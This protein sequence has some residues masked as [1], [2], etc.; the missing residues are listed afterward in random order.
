VGLIILALLLALF[1]VPPLRA[2]VLE[3]L[4]LGAVRIFLS[5]P[6]PTVSSPATTTPLSARTPVT[7][8]PSPP[9]TPSADLLNL[10]GETTLAEA[11]AQVDFPIRLP[12]EPLDLGS[13]DKVYLQD[14]NGPV[15]ILVWLDPDQPERVRLSLH[16]FGPNTLAGK[17]APQTLQETTVHDH[18]ALWVSG[19]HL[20]Q[21]RG[22][23]YDLIRLVEGKVLIWVE[24]DLTYRLETEGSLEEAVRMAESLR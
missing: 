4:Q 15:V 24:G 16:Q 7:T 9:P 1:S 22:Q 5:E 20:L 2:A 12:T 19:P 10:A 13:P 18:P 6:T 3:V 14:L 23:E 21:V 11:Q 17:G 8:P